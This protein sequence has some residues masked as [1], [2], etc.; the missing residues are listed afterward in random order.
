MGKRLEAIFQMGAGGDA[1]TGLQDRLPTALAAR[2][3]IKARVLEN[4]G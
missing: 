3:L 4:G 2:E 1:R